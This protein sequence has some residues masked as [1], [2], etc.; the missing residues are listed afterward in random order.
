MQYKN[1]VPVYNLLLPFLLL[2]KQFANSNSTEKKSIRHVFYLQYGYHR[3][4]HDL[5]VGH[6]IFKCFTWFLYNISTVRLWT[7]FSEFHSQARC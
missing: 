1:R 4:E 7:K 3:L 5:K 2:F 6:C